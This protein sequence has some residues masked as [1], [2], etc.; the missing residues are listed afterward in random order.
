MATIAAHTSGC[1]RVPS[2]DECWATA[3]RTARAPRAWPMLPRQI[4]ATSSRLVLTHI[5]AIFS[6]TEAF[7]MSLTARWASSMLPMVR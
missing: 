4:S 5:L 3:S 2:D 6:Q 7:L 1:I